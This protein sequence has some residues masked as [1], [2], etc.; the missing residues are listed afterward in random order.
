MQNLS[1]IKPPYH[2]D[3]YGSDIVTLTLGTR[4]AL[5]LETP[6]VVDVVGS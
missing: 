1:V 3:P 6:A 2:T 4:V 5:M